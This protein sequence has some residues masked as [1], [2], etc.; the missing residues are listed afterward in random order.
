MESHHD[1]KPSELLAPLKKGKPPGDFFEEAHEVVRVQ[2][3]K[4]DDG[5]GENLDHIR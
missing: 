3:Y 4:K 2:R 5:R 1:G